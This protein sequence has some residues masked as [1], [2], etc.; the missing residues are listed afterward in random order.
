[1]TSIQIL[2]ETYESLYA[3]TPILAKFL[4]SEF[5]NLSPLQWRENYVEPVLQKSCFVG[6]WRNLSDIDCYYLLELLNF[7]WKAFREK[8][9]SDFFTWENRNLFI[10][11]NN[12]N[13]LIKIRN[14]F[15]YPAQDSYS[16]KDFVAWSKSIEDVT[17]QLG[18]FLEKLVKQ[19]HSAEKGKILENLFKHTTCKTLKSHD[20]LEGHSCKHSEHKRQIRSFA[21]R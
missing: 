5:K 3:I 1:M 11:R 4:E 17:L 13:P 2:K 12:P 9:E 19:L 21:Y 18:S 10:D 7:Y 20:L 16:S 6:E 15:S 14:E 8:T